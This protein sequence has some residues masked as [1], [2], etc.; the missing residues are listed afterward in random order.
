MANIAVPWSIAGIL[1]FVL[2]V[3]FLNPDKVQIWGSLFL[4]GL[5]GIN[6]YFARRIIS[7]RIQGLVNQFAKRFDKESTGI[8]PCSLKIKWV[9]EVDRDALIQEEGVVLVRLGHHHDELQKA[10]ALAM[11]TFCSKSLIADSRPYLTNKLVR[12]IDFVTTKR[13]LHGSKNRG[14]LDYFLNNIMKA[15]IEEDDSLREKCQIMETLDEMGYFSRMLLREYQELGR[16]MYPQTPNGSTA[17]E[18]EDFLNFLEE[19]ATKPSEEDVELD[20]KGNRIQ[21]AVMLVARPEK[22][23]KVGFEP[24]LHRLEKH[25]KNRLETAYICGMEDNVAYVMRIAE[26]AEKRGLGMIV[27]TSKFRART[28]RR[29]TVPSICITFDIRIPEADE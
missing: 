4:K 26:R 11:L 21:T 8:M 19:I 1:L 20:F 22:I 6:G 29:R 2:V 12:S 13:M 28:P 24:Y 18:S 14:S 7:G 9:R 25:Q 15:E 5:G 27:S 10:L 23:A 3:L 16:K 17:V